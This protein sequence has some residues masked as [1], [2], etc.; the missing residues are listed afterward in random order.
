MTDPYEELLKLLDNTTEEEKMLIKMKE[1]CSKPRVM[2]K[3]DELI[4]K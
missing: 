3:M 1:F 4:I 2:A